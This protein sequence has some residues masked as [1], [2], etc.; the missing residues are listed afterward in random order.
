MGMVPPLSANNIVDSMDFGKRKRLT[1]AFPY[2]NLQEG[3]VVGG[4]CSI[5]FQEVHHETLDWFAI[6][7]PDSDFRSG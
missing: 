5:H 6:A 2:I 1:S 4:C 7:M 3:D